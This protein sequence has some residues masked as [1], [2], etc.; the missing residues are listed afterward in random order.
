MNLT[1]QMLADRAPKILSFRCQVELRNLTY[2]Y[3]RRDL[4]I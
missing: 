4:Y 3:D 1:Q 2:D